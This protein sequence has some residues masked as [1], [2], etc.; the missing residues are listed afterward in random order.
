MSDSVLP[1]EV[2]HVI[3]KTAITLSESAS[4]TITLIGVCRAVKEWMEPSLYHTV[5]ILDSE[6]ATKFC[7]SIQLR[8]ERD[9]STS[10]FATHVK[11]LTLNWDINDTLMAHIL[12]A[13]TDI[14]CLYI[15]R[16]SR[17]PKDHTCI[18][19]VERAIS[20]LRPKHIAFDGVNPAHFLRALQTATHIWWDTD[21]S[22]SAQCCRIPF[23][24]DPQTL[25]EV[26]PSLTHIM[27][28]MKSSS[29]H[30]AERNQGD[31]FSITSAIC[32]IVMSECPAL[33]VLVILPYPYL[34]NTFAGDKCWRADWV[35]EVKDPRC[36]RLLPGT[37]SH[38]PHVGFVEG[39]LLPSVISS[40]LRTN[41]EIWE[42]AEREV[43]LRESESRFIPPEYM[44][45]STR[46]CLIM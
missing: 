5:A 15:T 18:D 19:S 25:R 3:F 12:E 39:D 14:Q 9:P 20:S 7:S 45:H 41:Q 10:F 36:I 2:L 1:P 8:R 37:D 38:D 40:L 44:E 13:C 35:R 30:S 27:M 33:K 4:V 24:E 26:F 42:F 43:A 6:T 28:P 31:M 11:E 32:G 29:Y 17:E 46:D 22:D 34:V 16:S 23:L 21:S